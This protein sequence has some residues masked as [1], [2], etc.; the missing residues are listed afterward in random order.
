LRILQTLVNNQHECSLI[1]KTG[2]LG[3]ELEKTLY[4]TTLARELIFMTTSDL[5]Q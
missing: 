1:Q 5:V 4:I 3:A 2:S